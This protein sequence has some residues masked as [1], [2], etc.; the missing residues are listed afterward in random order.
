[1]GRER[2]KSNTKLSW[3]AQS[4]SND[5]KQFEYLDSTG[6]EGTGLNLYLMPKNDVCLARLLF[7]AT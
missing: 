1:M 6:S 2:S 5:F 3:L 4:L 7:S